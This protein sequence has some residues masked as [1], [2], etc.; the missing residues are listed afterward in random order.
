MATFKFCSECNNMLY[1]KEDRE[2]KI[3]LFACRNCDHQ[4]ESDN[5]CVYR[6][7]IVHVPS[8]QTMILTDLG[9]DPTLPRTNI[10]CPSCG[11]TE[12]VFFQS[13][14]R[15]PETKMTLFYVCCNSDC[16]HRWVSA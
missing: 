9:F 16:N 1:P 12:A 11:H 8:E 3:L 10:A 15:R 6:H 14:S 4:E 13:R 2:N 5:N 7:Q